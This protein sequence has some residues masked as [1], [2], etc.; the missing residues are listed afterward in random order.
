VRLLEL[1]RKI[2]IRW[3]DFVVF[4]PVKNEEMMCRLTPAAALTDHAVPV[5]CLCKEIVADM[6]HCRTMI[7]G[8]RSRSG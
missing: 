8:G 2:R 1:Y 3:W 7:A 4:Q 5:G 6:T